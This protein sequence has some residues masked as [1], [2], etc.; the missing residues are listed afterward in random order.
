MRTE[1]LIDL[2]AADA[3]DAA[4]LGGRLRRG[5]AA[6]TLVSVALLLATIGLRPDL[7][8]ALATPRVLFKIGF[9][10][11][12]AAVAIASAFRVGVPGAR[13][14][15]AL[16]APP[17]LVLI[18][19]VVGELIA[20]PAGSWPAR[21]L[22]QHAAF[23]VFFIPTLAL[24]PLAGL[25]WALRDGAPDH[26][27]RAGGLAGLAAGGVAAAI[28]AWHCPDDSPLFVAT[29]YVIAIGLVT[30]AGFLAGRRLLRW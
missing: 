22:G 11:L 13:V 7:A 12:L 28:Y 10:L 18:A 29:W 3:A 8:A 23:C 5:L 1:T 27:G 2:L 6:G 9:T 19:G 16:L 26:P 25:L 20:A 4:P 17:A 30:A 14:R 21:L 24:L 15:P